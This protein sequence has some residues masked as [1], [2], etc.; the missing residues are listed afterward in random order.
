[1]VFERKA[2]GVHTSVSLGRGRGSEGARLG[3]AAQDID[4][5]ALSAHG[6]RP[7]EIRHD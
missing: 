1:M 6:T 2:S 7:T 4:D 5:R 3:V